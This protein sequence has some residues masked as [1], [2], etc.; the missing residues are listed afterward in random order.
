MRIRV[1][2]LIA[3]LLASG[4]T[5]LAAAQTSGIDTAQ[6]KAT[7]RVFKSGLFSAFAHNH[8]VVAPVASGKLDRTARTIELTF[9]SKEMK[10]TDPGVSEKDRTAIDRDMKSDKVLDVERY[11]EIKFTSRSVEP[12]DA[13]RFLVRGDLTLRGVTKPVE[14]PVAFS[15][16]RYT[17]E[18]EIKQT[19]FGITPIKIAGGTVKVKDV[20][21]I[22]LEIVPGP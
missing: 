22:S 6:S 12:T 5:V 4:L 13:N 20:I 10:V 14:L 21:E 1:S 11:P 9:L 19:E 2:L 7:I 18:I 8:I 17:G 3:I 15:G 16:Q